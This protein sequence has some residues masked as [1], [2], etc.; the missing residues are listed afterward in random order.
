MHI[1]K[2]LKGYFVF[3]M[4][5]AVGAVV[6]SSDLA[7]G[8]LASVLN[9]GDVKVALKA[10]EEVNSEAAAAK[11]TAKLELSNKAENAYAE[12]GMK[13]VTLMDLKIGGTTDHLKLDYLKLRLAGVEA[14]KVEKIYLFEGEKLLGET[15]GGEENLEIKGLTIEVAVGEEKSYQVKVDLS[16]ELNSGERLRID[17]EKSTESFIKGPYLSIVRVE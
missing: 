16:P 4:M 7:T 1:S 2:I 11:K 15:D 5:I 3:V 12:P 8:Y 10:G 17:L 14:D 13:G 9:S 6:N